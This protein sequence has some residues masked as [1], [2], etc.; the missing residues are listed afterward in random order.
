MFCASVVEIGTEVLEKILN[1]NIVNVFLLLSHLEKKLWP[2][3]SINRDLFYQSMFCA[4]FGRNCPNGSGEDINV[5]ILQTHRQTAD[6][7]LIG[8]AKMN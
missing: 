7:R 8:K 1:L 2:F 3:I 5:K 6:N 4:K